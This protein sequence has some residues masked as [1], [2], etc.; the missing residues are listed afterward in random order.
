[1]KICVVA[2]SGF[3]PAHMGGPANVGF[4][5]SREFARRGHDTTV[6]AR[7][8]NRI[9]ECKIMQAMHE[10]G[11]TG[12]EIKTIRARYSSFHALV[13]GY[14]PWKIG[15]T[16]LRFATVDADVVI[17]N[18]PPVDAALLLPIVARMKNCK[19]IAIVHGGLFN[20]LSNFL[21]RA[22]FRHYQSLFDAVV[23]MSQYVED[24]LLASG[25]SPNSIHLIPNGVDF[26]TIQAAPSLSL[27]G[28]PKI[29]FVG[30]L[31]PVKGVST[32]IRAFSRFTATFANAHLYI[33]GTGSEYLQL[34][35]EASSFG[36]GN[37]VQFTG[38]LPLREV[39]SYYRSCDIL[40]LPSFRENFPLVLLESMAVGIPV[41]AATGQGGAA[42]LIVDGVNGFLFP[43][44]NTD[45]LHSVL[46]NVWLNT[47]Q[48]N[49]AAKEALRLVSASFD[50]ESIADRYLALM[51]D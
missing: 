1:M 2:L 28:H 45:E 19:Q 13:P 21:G 36:L 12:L 49:L 34:R 4:F 39:Y 11:L 5:L 3:Y 46:R 44:G 17:Y 40:V 33:V 7:T 35:D 30:R 32:L 18:S 15:E 27:E 26:D 9:E 38:L 43:P 41:V 25:F 22:I 23:T 37:R 20:E 48:R 8:N 31:E 42:E 24:L 50:W 51:G 47:D 6:L 16:T 14:V 10:Q 29:L